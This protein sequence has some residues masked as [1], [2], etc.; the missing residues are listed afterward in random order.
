MVINTFKV[1]SVS[2]EVKIDALIGKVINTLKVIIR[3]MP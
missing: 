3:L 1:I 2:K